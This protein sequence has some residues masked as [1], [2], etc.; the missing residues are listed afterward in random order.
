MNSDPRRPLDLDTLRV[1]P[2][3]VEAL[4][5]ARPAPMRSFEEYF[6]FLAQFGDVDPVLLRERPV[7]RGCP[8][9]KL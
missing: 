3:D 4:R 8:P 7:P 1:T 2:R 6:R 9:F 5:R